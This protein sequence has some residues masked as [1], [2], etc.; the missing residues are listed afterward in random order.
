MATQ[1]PFAYRQ[2]SPLSS[3][4]QAYFSG[5][6]SVAQSLSPMKGFARWQLEV[7]G[8]MSRR[9]QAYMEIPSRLQRCRTPQDLVNEQSRF[10]RTTFEQYTEASQ[11]I[12][13]ALQMPS[14][15]SA[16]ATRTVSRDYISFGDSSGSGNGAPPKANGYDRRAA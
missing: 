3:S 1:F 6:D 9:A 11:R 15:F 7:M 14:A 8:L 2:E 10:L 4:L 16:P 12:A 13:D 5:L